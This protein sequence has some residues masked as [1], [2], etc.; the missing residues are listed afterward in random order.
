MTDKQQPRTKR[1]PKIEKLEL[2][3][4]T[5]Q[6]LTELEAEEAKGGMVTKSLR[7]VGCV[8]SNECA[9]G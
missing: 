4:D 9:N 5:L 8:K 2:R 1:Q 3:K 6:D 7:P